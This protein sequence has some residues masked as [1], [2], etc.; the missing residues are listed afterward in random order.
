MWSKLTPG[1]EGGG[2]GS[3]AGGGGGGL[4]A[5]MLGFEAP[6]SEI[7]PGRLKGSLLLT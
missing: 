5:E 2:V 3:S 4:A 6:G 7:G 1:G